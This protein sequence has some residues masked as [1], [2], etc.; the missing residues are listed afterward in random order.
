MLATSAPAASRL[1]LSLLRSI[2]NANGKAANFKNA[3]VSVVQYA[4]RASGEVSAGR[5]AIEACD[6]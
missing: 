2:S 4:V 3:V 6:G 1:Q 5:C